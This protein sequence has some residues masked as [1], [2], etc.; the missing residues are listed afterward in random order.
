[1]AWK[2]SVWNAVRVDLRFSAVPFTDIR[3]FMRD[4]RT[5]ALF[6]HKCIHMDD[7][8]QAHH[9]YLLLVCA[10]V[11]HGLVFAL[12]PTGWPVLEVCVKMMNA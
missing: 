10:Q 2:Q 7:D 12:H 6:V 9:A 8:L 5:V 11:M 1:M 3:V 4:S